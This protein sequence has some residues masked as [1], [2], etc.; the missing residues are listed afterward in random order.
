MVSNSFFEKVK[1]TVLKVVLFP[2]ILV[3]GVN[4]VYRS[5][6]EIDKYRNNKG[7]KSIVPSFIYWLDPLYIYHYIR[8]ELLGEEEMHE[9]YGLSEEELNAGMALGKKGADIK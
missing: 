4:I 3:M 6:A 8:A 5:V 1:K 7:Y 9:K 2:V